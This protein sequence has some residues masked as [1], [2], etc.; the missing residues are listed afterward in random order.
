VGCGRG[1]LAVTLAARGWAMEGVEPS[2]A[3]CAA[4]ERRG[5]KVHRGTATSV[6]LEPA[7]YDF[8]VFRHS[9]E[10][11]S[12]PV[13]GLRAVGEALPGGL[14]LVSVPNFASRQA[15]AFG[16]CWFHLDVPRHRVHFTPAA[17][18]RASR[19]AGLEPLSTSLSSGAAGLP[20]SLQYRV[21]GRCLFPSGLGLR[22]A[23]GLCA[24]A[25]PAALLF[26]RGEGDTLHAV[27]RRPLLG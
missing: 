6:A 7:A 9:L 19:A 22:V 23:V 4:A 18:E 17:L 12:D 1:D 16:D 8:T 10:H 2:A 5:I 27:A 24:L 20:A 26:D 3:A 25:L 11:T 15:R 14:V 13:A 21:F